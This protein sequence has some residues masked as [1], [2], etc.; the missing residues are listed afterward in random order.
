MK[1]KDLA[2]GLAE[3]VPEK[4]AFR[5]QFGFVDPVSDR[6]EVM[7]FLLPI[8]GERLLDLLKLLLSHI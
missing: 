4:C 7:A 3:E 6:L 5:S 1:G 8:A 2:G